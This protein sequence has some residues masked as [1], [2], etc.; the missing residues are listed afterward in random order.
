M[1]SATRDYHQHPRNPRCEV[2]VLLVP[3]LGQDFIADAWNNKLVLVTGWFLSWKLAGRMPD[4][5]PCYTPIWAAR[6]LE[7]PDRLIPED[8]LRR[9]L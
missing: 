7:V 1:N 5:L 3:R 8:Q 4:G 2:R 9:V 6:V